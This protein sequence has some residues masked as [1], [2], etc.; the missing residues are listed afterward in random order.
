M[1]HPWASAN[2]CIRGI[3]VL[4]LAVYDIA[5]VSMMLYAQVATL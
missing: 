5:L 2:D 4:Q 1:C 3:Q